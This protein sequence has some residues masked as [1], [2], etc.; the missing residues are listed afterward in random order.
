MQREMRV[1][2]STGTRG[3]GWGD[4]TFLHRNGGKMTMITEGKT[5]NLNEETAKHHARPGA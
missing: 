4:R 1:A 5:G 3:G 2:P